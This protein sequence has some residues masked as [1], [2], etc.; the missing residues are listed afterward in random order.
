M[1]KGDEI[2]MMQLEYWEDNDE[3][4]FWGQ[5]PADEWAD[6]DVDSTYCYL[7]TNK[8]RPVMDLV[9]YGLY[10]LGMIDI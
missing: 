10:S 9:I 7:I 3:N 4:Y 6:T 5:S 2:D 1:K 8:Q